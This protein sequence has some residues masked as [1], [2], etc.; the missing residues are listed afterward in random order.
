MQHPLNL[1]GCMEKEEL[2]RKR[3]LEKAQKAYNSN[4]YMFTEFLDL[5]DRDVY[6]SMKRELSFIPNEEWGGM[7]DCERVMVCFGSVEAFGY[8]GE[9]PIST[10]K[11]SPLSAKFSDNLTHRDFLGS[12]M[13]LGIE[14]DRLG[15][16]IIEENT[17]YLFCCD[18]IAKFIADNLFRVKHTSVSCE[19]SKDGPEKIQKEPEYSIIQVQSLRLD[20]VIAKA[21]NMSRGLSCEYIIGQKVFLNGRLCE[22]VSQSLKEG[23]KITVRGKG[24]FK[25]NAQTGISKKGKLNIEIEKNS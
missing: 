5:Y 10:I 1:R 9:Y 17:A 8:E 19:I 12:L 16:I 3:L 21:F 4:V 11:I 6:Y 22:S 2:L 18:N 25:I 15:D 23:D 20:T 24:R 13:N 7:A 14:R